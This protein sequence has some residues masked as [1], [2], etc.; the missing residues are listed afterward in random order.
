MHGT[1]S[2][3]LKQKSSPFP[4]VLHNSD[5]LIV[6]VSLDGAAATGNRLITFTS[7]SA[8]GLL[9]GLSRHCFSW[10]QQLFL[11]EYSFLQNLQ[12]NWLLFVAFLFFMFK[13]VLEQCLLE[14]MCLS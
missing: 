4:L 3:K 11:A 2:C 8:T 5:K 14:E 1:M 9:L 13:I 7:A 12:M 6:T 10:Y